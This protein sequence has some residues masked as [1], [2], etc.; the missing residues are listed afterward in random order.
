MQLREGGNALAKRWR[1]H[2]AREIR[3]GSLMEQLPNPENRIRPDFYERYVDKAAAL[4]HLEPTHTSAPPV[5][6][7]RSRG[8]RTV[9]RMACAPIEPQDA[10]R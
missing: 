1:D 6:A 2:V 5:S 9:E 3:F 8:S 4:G 10:E 7:T